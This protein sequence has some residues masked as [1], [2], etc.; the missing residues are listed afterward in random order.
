MDFYRIFV[1]RCCSYMSCLN[2]RVFNSGNSCLMLQI[3]KRQLS[4]LFF[5][6]FKAIFCLLPFWIRVYISMWKINSSEFSIHQIA[7]LVL[8]HISVSLLC[9]LTFLIHTLLTWNFKIHWDW[10]LTIFNARPLGKEWVSKGS[11]LWLVYFQETCGNLCLSSTMWG[12][13]L[14]NRPLANTKR[15]PP[16]Y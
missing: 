16:C 11:V 3:S 4:C 15:S 8:F 6:Y 12:I 1:I 7:L 10:T 14:N 9:L 2:N 5:V 13:T